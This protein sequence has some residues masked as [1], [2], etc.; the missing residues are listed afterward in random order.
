[1]KKTINPPRTPK[2]EPAKVTIA[3]QDRQILMLVKR[4]QDLVD[5]RDIL[6]TELQETQFDLNDFKGRVASSELV[7]QR[8]LGWQDCAREML[9]RMPVL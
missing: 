4:C 5:E 6:K 8:L 3:N 7:Y 1:M 9:A 2:D